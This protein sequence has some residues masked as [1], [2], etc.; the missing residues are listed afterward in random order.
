MATEGYL[1]V[2]GRVAYVPQTPWLFK[3]T[4]RE[5]IVFGEPFDSIRYYNTIDACCL[6]Q[7]FGVMSLGDLT[8]TD[9]KGSNLSGGTKL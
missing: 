6:T 7:D 5:N 2:I 9:G 4:L 8:E 3:G 1:Q